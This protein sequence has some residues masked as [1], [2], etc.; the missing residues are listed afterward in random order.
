MS[1]ET[2]VTSSADVVVVGSGSAGAVVA[3]RLVDA[4]ASVLLLEAGLPDENPAIHDP[5]RLFELWDS[6]QDWGYRTVP[7]VG[8][9]GARAALAAR[10]GARRVER[11]QRDDLRAR[12]PRRLRRLGSAR[13]RRLGLRRRPA[14]LQALGGL[15]P[16]G[17]RVPRR[18]RAPVG[19]HALRAAPGDRGGRGGGPGG[20]RPVQRRLERRRARRR[21]LLPAEHPGRSAPRCRGGLPASRARRAQPHGADLRKGVPAPLRGHALRRGGVRAGRGGAAGA[22]RARGRRLRRDDRVAQAAAC[23]RGSAPRP[24]FGG[25]ASSRSSTSPASARTCTTTC[26]PR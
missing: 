24:T 16:R 8:V 26:S 9:R 11:A 12:P 21:R 25:W 1:S 23:S 22:G 2:E 13:E 3:R 14:A 18:R 6:E 10:E 7:Q 19:D 17:G 5:A 15:R 20:R 4:G